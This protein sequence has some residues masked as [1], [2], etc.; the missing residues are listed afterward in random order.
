[1]TEPD[2]KRIQCQGGLADGFEYET[3]IEPPDTI[4]LMHTEWRDGQWVRVLPETP[5]AEGVLIVEYVRVPG[6]EQFGYE[7]IYYPAEEAV[8]A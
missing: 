6:V 5:R 1:M 2:W 3:V 8:P 7:R 4:V